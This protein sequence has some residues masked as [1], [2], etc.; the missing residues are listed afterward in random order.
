MKQ[1]EREQEDAGV[2]GPFQDERRPVWLGESEKS[3]GRRGGRLDFTV[4][5][6]SHTGE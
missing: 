6:G 4:S 5:D 2:L 1:K 3:S